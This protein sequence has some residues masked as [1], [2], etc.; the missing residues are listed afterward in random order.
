MRVAILDDYQNT[1]LASADWSSV[2]SQAE[3]EVFNDHIHDEDAVAARLQDFEIICAMRERTPFPRSLIEK[4]PNL[5]LIISSGMR[6]RG[7]DVDAAKDNN[8]IVC[9]TKSVGKPTAE[10]AWGLI[11]G[12]ARKIPAEDSNVKA[13][14]W[15][16]T[17]GE[18]LI[19]KTLGIAGLGNLG[20]R[21]AQ[22]GKA[23]DMNVIAWSQN[24]TQERCDEFGVQLVSKDELMAQSDYLTIHL[25][26]S[27]RTRGVISVDDLSRMK[28]T[29][30]IINTARGPIIDE[31]ALVTALQNKEIA[32]AG[33]DV[34]SVEPLPADHP[35][36]SLQN[37]II[38]PHLGYVE[39]DNYGA[40]FSGYV[41]AIDAFLKGEPKNFLGGY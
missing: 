15:Q 19:G 12:L 37:T 3:I 41:E 16:Q 14:G 2:S 30:Y 7:I 27:D 32:G 39:A 9:G 17:V 36:R 6:N 13:G 8:V 34:F 23:F 26:L 10:L 28:S 21:M 25:I 4:L 33:I 38:T 31:D 1:A 5:K 11:L 18:G 40:Y 22:I 35:F 24:L 20:G 29:A